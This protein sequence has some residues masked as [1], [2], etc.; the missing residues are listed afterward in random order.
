LA[1]FEA[2]EFCHKNKAKTREWLLRCARCC[3]RCTGRVIRLFLGELLRR[4]DLPPV[5]LEAE[6]EAERASYFSALE[7]MDAGDIAPLLEIWKQRFA[8]EPSTGWPT[9][10]VTE[11]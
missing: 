1:G 11:V 10:P 3:Q 7:S 6:E 9:N 2:L 4:L 5:R 8:G